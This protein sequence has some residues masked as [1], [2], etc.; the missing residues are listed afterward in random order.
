MTEARPDR[1][2][3]DAARLKQLQAGLH[4]VRGGDFSVPPGE[5]VSA[6]GEIRNPVG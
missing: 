5:P 2:L 6:Y 4:A 3:L 1:P